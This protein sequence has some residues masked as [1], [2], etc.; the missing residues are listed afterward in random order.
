MMK[1]ALL[2]IDVQN[3]YFKNGKMELVNPDLALA[4]T[5]LLEDHFIQNNLPIIYI[6]H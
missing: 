2:I 5:N 3:D 4:Q 1:Q 6:Q